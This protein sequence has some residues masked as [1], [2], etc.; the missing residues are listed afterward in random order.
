MSIMDLAPEVGS[1]HIAASDD[2]SSSTS[3]TTDFCMIVTAL[4]PKFRAHRRIQI[5]I[6]RY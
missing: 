4:N 1:I 3:L 6:Y 5:R 2:V